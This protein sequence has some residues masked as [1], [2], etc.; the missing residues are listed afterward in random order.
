MSQSHTRKA[1][2]FVPTFDLLE[3]RLVPAS[4]DPQGS[5]LV[6]TG[7]DKADKIFITDFGDNHVKV[8]AGRA[9]TDVTGISNIL[10]NTRGG[11]DQVDYTLAGD[12]TKTMNVTANLGKDNDTFTAHLGG[13]SLAGAALNFNVNGEDGND[14]V[15]IDGSTGTNLGAG[16]GL[17]ANLNGGAGKDT[18]FVPFN[19][20]IGQNAFLRVQMSGGGDRDNLKT[21]YSGKNDGFLN[22][23]MSG[24]GDKDTLDAE[25]NLAA[26]STGGVGTSASP[27]LLQGGDGNDT[28][29]FVV[30]TPQGSAPV[31]ASVLGQGGTDT[32]TRTANVS[33]DAA[34]PGESDGVVA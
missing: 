22:L 33:S 32:F 13:H 27:A 23:G 34:V 30:H 8:R 20:D 16:T 11:K 1:A 29:T 21:T 31:F 15:R 26:G 25:V 3:N 12:L 10:I 5:T 4:I 17:I 7:N 6:I 19:G 24:D 2:R 14:N 9:S 18:L 28:M